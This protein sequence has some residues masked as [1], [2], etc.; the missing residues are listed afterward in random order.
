MRRALPFL[1]FA[2]VAVVMTS[3]TA[4][5]APAPRPA[6]LPPAEPLL[7]VVQAE[8]GALEPLGGGSY[9]LTLR[10]VP[11]RAVWFS[12]RPARD[13]GAVPLRQLTG[14]YWRGLGFAADPPNAVVTLSG[15]RR[16]ADTVALELTRP[17]Y[18]ARRATVRFRA[19][20]L[21]ELTP[22]LAHH[23]A[24]LDRRLPRRF[25]AASLF[26]DDGSVAGPASCDALAEV[27]LYPASI[28]PAFSLPAAGQIVAIRGREAL[29]SL[30]GAGFGGTVPTSFGIPG[31]TAPAGLAYRLCATGALFPVPR[32]FAGGDP[33]SYPTNCT[34]GTVVLKA[35]QAVPAGWTP[36]D[37]S[38][39]GGL[40]ITAPPGLRYDLCSGGPAW[41]EGTQSSP[42]CTLGQV[43]LFVTAGLPSTWTPADGRTLRITDEMALFNLINTAFGGDGISTFALPAVTAPV[44]G[45]RYAVCTGGAY[46]SSA[47]S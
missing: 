23:A 17:R 46:P 40:A 20:L 22:G 2:L 39:P 37:G 30:I 12:D 7:F 14:A 9:A 36:A 29:F 33:A 45:T 38:V 31:V 47:V 28:R 10:G 43:K 24:R 42:Q 35:Q 16:G 25:G 13:T 4:A 11:S 44:A 18:D 5:A 32:D 1:L 27:D 21:R 34:K 6:G 3:A 19:R 26:I 41:A 8:G 15:G